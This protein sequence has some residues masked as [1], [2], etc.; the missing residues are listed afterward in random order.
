MFEEPYEPL[1][2]AQAVSGDAVARTEATILRT[3]AL[4][5]AGHVLMGGL[6]AVTAWRSY[7]RPNVMLAALGLT[8]LESRWL[9]RRCGER[10]AFDEP[11]AA[12]VDLAAGVAGIA[13]LGAATTVEDRTTW[14][15]WMAPL[16]NTTAAALAL[17]LDLGPGSVGTVLLGG[18]YLATAVTSI[19]RGGNFASTATANLLSYGGFF[20]AT[21]LVV[22]HLRRSA[23]D[24][25]AART[26][27]VR[28]A[29]RLAG[30]RERNRQH[31]LVHDS[32]LQTLE[33]VAAGF[34]SGSD[35][36]LR[37][38]ARDEGVRLRSA[39][40]GDDLESGELAVGL[41]GL[42]HNFTRDGLEVDLVLDELADE[43]EVEATAALFDATAE[44]LRNVA[45]HAGTSRCS[46]RLIGRR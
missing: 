21:N 38:R 17:G 39:L 8:A 12:W 34:G 31:R 24:L 15:N 25:E 36:A 28:S 32:A 23:F 33:A 22:R 10:G 35:V 1:D 20:F 43:P 6:C 41:R 13:A 42:V 9:L 37:D 5:R 40:R 29:Q 14:V 19:R 18:T 46:A 44:A 27:A 7:R 26:E 3:F 2:R 16:A 30:E 45:K 4:A 11:L